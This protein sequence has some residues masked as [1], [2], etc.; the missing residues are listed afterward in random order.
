VT[1]VSPDDRALLEEAA[2][3]V[4]AARMAL[5]AM[6]YLESIA[7]KNQVT[8]TMLH[9][10]TPVLGIAV[11]PGVLARVAHLLERRETIPEFVRLLD[12][13]KEARRRQPALPPGR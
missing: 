11:S 13:A 2:R 6:M 3:R 10:L 7:P 4:A 8:A 12:A 5:P 1:E 9:M